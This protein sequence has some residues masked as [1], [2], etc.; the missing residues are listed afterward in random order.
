VRIALT[1]TALVAF[2]ANSLLCRMSL[3][4]HLVDPTAFTAVRLLSG[5]VV[6]VA[7]SVVSGARAGERKRI[8]GSWRSAVALF[9]YALAFSWAYVWLEAGTGAL[10][11][12]GAV[13]ATMIGAGMFRGERP[14]LGEWLG[15][16]AAMAGLVYLALPGL[17]GPNRWVVLW[18]A[19]MALAGVAWGVY[20][21][22]GRTTVDAV[23]DTAGNFV[24]AVPLA[25]LAFALPWGSFEPHARGIVLAVI[26][27]AL[28]SGLGYVIWYRALRELSAT[29][30]AIVQLTVPVL[31][32]AGGVLLLGERPTLRLFAAGL[33][34]LGGVLAAILSRR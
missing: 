29:T 25:A 8:G 7:L 9:V 4:A 11:L 13:Q 33:A 12:F 6:L 20:S 34:I 1:V 22:R 2:A 32:A 26:S 18:V 15:L 14:R 27:G 3:A 23:R 19:L 10:V 16:A 24:R 31:A 28:A 30:A 21:L 5:A 17:T